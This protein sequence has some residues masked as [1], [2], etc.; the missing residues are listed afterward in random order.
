MPLCTILLL[1]RPY[2]LPAHLLRVNLR[3]S[4]SVTNKKQLKGSSND[5]ER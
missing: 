5:S 1:P 3:L 4:A 2:F